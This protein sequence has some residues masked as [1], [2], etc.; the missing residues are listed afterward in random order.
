[1][2]L[3]SRQRQVLHT[4]GVGVSAVTLR[5]V[6]TVLSPLSC[7]Y[8]YLISLIMKHMILDRLQTIDHFSVYFMFIAQFHVDLWYFFHEM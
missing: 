6:R 3:L 2:F 5:R 4:G 8:N 1:M 7:Q